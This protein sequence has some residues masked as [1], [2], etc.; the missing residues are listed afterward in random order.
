MGERWLF[1]F[2]RALQPADMI[3][4][5][6][7]RFTSTLEISAFV[8]VQIFSHGPYSVSCFVI[9]FSSP[10]LCEP[11]LAGCASNQRG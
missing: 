8:V 6:V 4:N 1:D 7:F 2:E 5:V 11:V 10:L 3:V 9:H